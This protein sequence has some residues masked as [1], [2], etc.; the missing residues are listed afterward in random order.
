MSRRAVMAV[1]ITRSPW[2]PAARWWWQTSRPATGPMAGLCRGRFRQGRPDPAGP[3][4]DPRGAAR[5]Q[6]RAR[7]GA[8]RPG[9]H[10]RHGRPRTGRAPAPPGR[11][12]A[13]QPPGRAASRPRSSRRKP[14]SRTPRPRG[15]RSQ[16]DLKRN[17]ALVKTNAGVGAARRPGARRPALGQRQGAGPAKRRSA[18]MRAPLGREREIKAAG[19]R[20]GGARRRRHAAVA[21]RP[22]PRRGAGRRHCRRRPGAARRDHPCRR[23]GGVAAAAGKHLRAVLRPGAAASP[24]FT[25]ATGSG[26]SATTARADLAATISFISPQAEYTPPVIYSESIR[27]KLVYMVEARPSP[28]QAASINPG[29]PIA[30]RPESAVA[31]AGPSVQ[32][33]S[34]A[35]RAR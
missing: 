30:V 33:A 34:G 23:A 7:H 4:D 3:P 21:A 28:E 13:R 27:A 25:S 17:E 31:D 15:T 24:R 19:G 2:P 18:Q 14:I 5:L 20:R 26:S 29:Q 12:A 9:R 32:Q 6:G 35:G 22:A 1:R 10:R 16:S 8:V 11:G